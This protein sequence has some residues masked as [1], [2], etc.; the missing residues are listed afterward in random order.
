MA[1]SCEINELLSAARFFLAPTTSEAEREAILIYLRVQ[2]LIA[3]GGADYSTSVTELQEAAKEW[4][5]VDPALR[6]TVLLQMSVEN[7]ITNGASI[8]T[9]IAALKENSR[10]Y[11]CMGAET[12][13]NVAA[14]LRCALNELGAPD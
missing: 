11:L 5:V 9:A 4:Q 3:A 10:C 7:A 2:G 1:L 14:F 6:E 12:R 8:D 13:R